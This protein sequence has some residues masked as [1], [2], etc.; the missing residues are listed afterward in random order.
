VNTQKTRCPYCSSVFTVSSA[1][2]AIREGYTRCGK[3]FQVFK[4]D[5][6]LIQVKGE[7]SSTIQTPPVNQAKQSSH[8]VDMH[9][10]SPTKS[11]GF[12]NALDSFLDTAAKQTQSVE[13]Q[14]TIDFDYKEK[15]TFSLSII[16]NSYPAP[17]LKTP[18][19]LS[20]AIQIGEPIRE[21]PQSLGQEFNEQWLSETTTTETPVSTPLSINKTSKVTPQ[22]YSVPVTPE[23]VTAPIIKNEAVDRNAQGVDDDLMSYLNKNSV[24]A[25]P[26]IKIKSTRVLPGMNDFHANQRSKKKDQPLPMHYQAPKRNVALDKLKERK[27]FISVSFLH[28]LG[29]LIV[30]LVM[31]ALL[32]GQ[33]IFFNFDQLAANP[34]Y[35]PMMHKACLK[36]GCDVPLIDI[37]QIRINKINAARY[38]ADPTVATKFTATMTNNATESQPFPTIRLTILKNGQVHAGRVLHPSEYLESGYNSQLR[39]FSKHPVKIEFV[40]KIAREEIPK[41][42]LDPVE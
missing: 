18:E 21:N 9:K 38:S 11:K 19:L 14:T 40:V 1:Q 25:A 22:D 2:L 16:P 28:T 27:P 10:I 17:E 29:W 12:N 32:F 5:D 33:Y 20:A 31:M 7:A 6:Y 36:F 24:A 26:V 4:A 41:Y 3:C 37:S 34:R 42:V 39:I 15:E 13:E 23:P 35:Q 30:S 8:I